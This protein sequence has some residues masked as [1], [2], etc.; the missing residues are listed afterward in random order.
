MNILKIIEKTGSLNASG[1]KAQSRRESLM[2]LGG[3]G[4]DIAMAALPF[5]AFAMMPKTAKSQDRG[6]GDDIVGILNF[7]LTLEYL[8]ASFYNQGVASGVIPAAD[9]AIFNQIKQHENAHVEFL[10][11]TIVALG[12]SPTASPTFDFTAGGA[13]SPFSAYA[14]FLALSQAFEDTGVRA[15]K[16]QAGGLMSNDAVLTAALQIHSVEARHASEVRRLRRHNGLDATLKGWISGSSNGTLPDATIAVYAGENNTTHG[17]VNATTTT[18]VTSAYIQ[19]AFD[20]PLSMSAVLDI[21]G[22]FIV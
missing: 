18:T 20:E 15:Y 21:A 12:G 16:G 5:A 3:F 10:S 4:K 11:E 14:E 7:A 22:L 6:G 9:Q 17:G 8:E 1:D 2:S 19:E 13:F